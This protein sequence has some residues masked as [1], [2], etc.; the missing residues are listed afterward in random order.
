MKGYR[1]V[2]IVPIRSYSVR[3]RENADQNNSEYKQFLR[4]VHLYYSTSNLNFYTR[5]AVETWANK[6][7]PNKKRQYM[8]LQFWPFKVRWPR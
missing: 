7:V 6:V 5:Y 2:K 1:C 4:S 8:A 3:M